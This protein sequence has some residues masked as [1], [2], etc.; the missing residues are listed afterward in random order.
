M[1]VSF[2]FTVAQRRQPGHRG[3]ALHARQASASRSMQALVEADASARGLA[4]V[5]GGR[6]DAE[7][8]ELAAR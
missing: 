1:I 4:Y 8:D 6:R 7:G 2:A 3:D 5:A